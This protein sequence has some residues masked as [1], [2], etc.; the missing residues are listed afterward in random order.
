MK[1]ITLL[2]M[3]ALFVSAVN[4]QTVLSHSTTQN[5]D[6]GAVACA[7]AGAG[8]TTENNYSRSYIPADFGQTGTIS[9]EGGEFGISF[10]DNGGGNPD[11][12]IFLNAY[13]TDAPYPGGTLTQ[14]ADGLATVTAG[15]NGTVVT[16]VFDIPVN[17][18][19][20][21]EIVLEMKIPTGET[22]IVDVRVGQNLDG[23]TGPSYIS[24]DSSCGPLAITTFDDL[25]FPGNIVLNLTVNDPILGVNDNLASLT[26]IYPNPTNDVLNVKLPSNVEVLNSSLYNILGQETGLK[27]ENGVI[28]TTNLV[29]GVYVLTVETSAG[30]LTQ[31]VV[32]Q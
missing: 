30:T 28:N 2:L 19:S 15:D 29:N 8:F 13:I 10:A 6:N 9:I 12:N 4:A 32:K 22:D 17:V 20:T 1:K 26:S 21:D 7:D 11:F 25:G 14:I 5:V 3:A 31:K 18:E 24:T 16:F 23:E 27:L